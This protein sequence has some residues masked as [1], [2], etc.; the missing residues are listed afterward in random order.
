MAEPT[1]EPAPELPVQALS[2]RAV[3]HHRRGYVV[4]LAGAQETEVQRD[5]SHVV[6]WLRGGVPFESGVGIDPI[7]GSFPGAKIFI[8]PTGQW[9]D[10]GAAVKMAAWA[11]RTRDGT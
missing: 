2:Q 1:E 6:H 4:D 11:L 9:S 8:P 7:E 5:R 3:L 10:G